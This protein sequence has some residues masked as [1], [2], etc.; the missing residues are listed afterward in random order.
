MGENLSVADSRPSAAS[1]G[2]MTVSQAVIE[3]RFERLLTDLQ[4]AIADPVVAH[5]LETFDFNAVIRVRESDHLEAWCLFHGAAEVDDTGHGA[6]A[7][8]E[9]TVPASLLEGFWTKHLAME[10]LEGRASYTGR[11]RQL[12]M[13]MPVIRAAVLRSQS[14][15]VTA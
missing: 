6:I 9:V 15:E 7:D 5:R 13:M 8:V 14:A 3:E 4:V 12:L 1:P 2:L 11:V 10:I